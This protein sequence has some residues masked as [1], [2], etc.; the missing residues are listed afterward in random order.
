M[1]ATSPGG[2]TEKE[3]IARIDPIR[4]RPASKSHNRVGALMF[5]WTGRG[6]GGGGGGRGWRGEWYNIQDNL[7]CLGEI[8]NSTRHLRT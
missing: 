4:V 3:R 7:P 1:V 5:R 2:F 8:Y 6:V